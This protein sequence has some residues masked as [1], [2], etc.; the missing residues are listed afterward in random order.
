MAGPSPSPC[1]KG[2][3]AGEGPVFRPQREIHSL[4]SPLM[5]ISFSEWQGPAFPDAN[6]EKRGKRASSRS[7]GRPLSAPGLRFS[8]KASQGALAGS[9]LA[10]DTAWR[11]LVLGLALESGGSFVRTHCLPRGLTQ[12]SG[13]CGLGC[14]HTQSW[15]PKHSTQKAGGRAGGLSVSVR[16]QP[17]GER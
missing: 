10:G 12:P 3:L 4:V 5:E 16:E 11:I 15:E 1:S 7:V 14:A 6:K 8:F 17:Y 9:D 2:P 13:P